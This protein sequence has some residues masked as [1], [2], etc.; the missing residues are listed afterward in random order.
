M[1]VIQLMG[2]D[3]ATEAGISTKMEFGVDMAYRRC[4][5]DDNVT[6]LVGFIPCDS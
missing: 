6:T 2:I 1:D 5:G 3:K 4:H